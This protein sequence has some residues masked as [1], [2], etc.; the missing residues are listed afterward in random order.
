LSKTIHDYCQNG[1][2]EKVIE[3]LDS[4]VEVDL[5]RFDNTPLMW[6]S[7]NNH[8]TVMK[9]LIKKGADVNLGIDNEDSAIVW[10]LKKGN[11][12]AFEL[13]IN[14]GAKTDFKRYKE[15]SS[16]NDFINAV[17]ENNLDFV[18][19][20][21]LNHILNDV[22]GEQWQRLV[23]NTLEWNK[24]RS[25]FLVRNR[26][27]R[28]K[29]FIEVVKSQDIKAIK[30]MIKAKNID[31]SYINFEDEDGISQTSIE[32]ASYDNDMNF[33]IIQLLINEDKDIKNIDNAFLNASIHGKTEIVKFLLDK[34]AD[35]NHSTYEGTS[36][37]YAVSQNDIDMVKLLLK[38]NPKLDIVGEYSETSAFEASIYLEDMTIYELLNEYQK[39]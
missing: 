32:Y 1:D 8:T 21:L 34:G 35:I 38:Y 39:N 29:K 27:E 3:L 13:L 22:W 2:L 5:L 4:G 24:N 17:E 25:A 20:Q 33:E 15:I 11:S 31:L 9:E 6:A 28:N 12:E 18:K 10:A 23:Y 16:F 36:L 26:I 7:Y 37:Y 19:E 14:N 30:K